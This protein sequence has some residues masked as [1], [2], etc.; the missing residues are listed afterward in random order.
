MKRAILS[1]TVAVVIAAAASSSFAANLTVG[2]DGKV[3]A[4]AAV[5][6]TAATVGAAAGSTTTAQTGNSAN[7]ATTTDSGSLVAAISSDGAIA[8]SVKQ[9]GNVSSV[10]V[11]KVADMVKA[12]D[13]Q[14]VDAA[15]TKSKSD[16]AKLQAAIA[17]NSKLKTKL[18]EK[19][20]KLSSVVALNVDAN[21]AVTVFVD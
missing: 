16:I 11:V 17:A 4:N 14:T 18:E 10:T 6:D 20:V 8:A 19:S 13:K 15:L 5:G 2:A 9:L 12:D 3:G 1:T 21:S 7:G